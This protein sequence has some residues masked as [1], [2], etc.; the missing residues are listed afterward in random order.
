[1]NFYHL[2]I[3][4]QVIESVLCAIIKVGAYGGRKTRKEQ[5]SDDN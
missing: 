1:M 4:G 3:L 5:G 2:D